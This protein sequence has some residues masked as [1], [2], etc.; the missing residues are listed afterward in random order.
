MRSKRVSRSA[1][2]RSIRRAGAVAALVAVGVA[3]A[4]GQSLVTSAVFA[5]RPAPVAG[6]PALRWSLTPPAARPAATIV[7]G[8]GRATLSVG[9]SITS[10]DLDDISDSD[11]ITSIAALVP[12]AA[13][14][15]R[16]TDRVALE[17]PLSIQSSKSDDEDRFTEIDVGIRP[18]IA[19]YGSDAVSGVITLMARLNR[20][21]FGDESSTRFGWEVGAGPEFR[22]NDALSLRTTAVYGSTAEDE[23]VN[24]PKETYLGLNLDLIHDLTAPGPRRSGG[25][26][27]RA[28]AAFTSLDPDEG[29]GESTIEVPSPYFGGYFN[30]SDCDCIRLGGEVQLS[31]IS[32][33]E[34]SQMDFT[35][36]PT[37]EYDLM[38]PDR[39]GFRLRGFGLLSR[40]SFDSGS[41]DQSGTITGF[42]GG[43]AGVFPMFNRYH[44]VLGLDY[45][46]AGESED[47]GFPSSNII[48][49]TF[50]IELPN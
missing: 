32:Q 9:A 30:L 2:V 27:I 31:R 20:Q 6:E 22:L 42:G 39:F 8:R 34:F 17:F 33:G 1:V 19:I 23:D 16:A 3:P 37:I 36:L 35:I 26:M 49:V 38:P 25:F 5:Q 47:I 40:Q 4:E 11:R 21:S 43:V 45:I 46:K 28:G 50:G 10:I 29:D 24:V 7:T 18:A 12:R 44:G 13:I 14:G 48:R 15:F 41:F